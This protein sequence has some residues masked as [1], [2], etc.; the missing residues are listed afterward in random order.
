MGRKRVVVT[1]GTSG[2]GQAAVAQL[3][4][5]GAHVIAQ[6][7]DVEKGRRVVDELRREGDVELATADLSSLA[8]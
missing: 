4:R 2:I 1:G 5:A 7:R 6:G 3:A 8:S